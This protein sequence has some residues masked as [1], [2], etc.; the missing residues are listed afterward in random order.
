MPSLVTVQDW[1]KDPAKRTIPAPSG[2]GDGAFRGFH[3][4]NSELLPSLPLHRSMI[5]QPSVEIVR[6]ARGAELI[7][8]RGPHVAALRVRRPLTPS[9]V[10]VGG[11]SSAFRHPIVISASRILHRN[12]PQLSCS[13]L[14]LQPNT[15]NR[16]RAAGGVLGARSP[17]SMDFS[18]LLSPIPCPFSQPPAS[19]S[20]A[21]PSTPSAARCAARRHSQRAAAD[22]SASSRTV[23]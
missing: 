19:A 6:P 20:S 2:G 15:A 10:S 22:R 8:P 4:P 9:S 16:G 13:E 1:W 12:S 23:R 17:S 3:Q 11:I 14:R 5:L 7:T 21:N 18:P